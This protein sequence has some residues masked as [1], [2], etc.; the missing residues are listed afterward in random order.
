MKRSLTKIIAMLLMV[1]LILSGCVIKNAGTKNVPQKG[2]VFMWE[3][4]DKSGKGKLYLLGS[5]HAA[6]E[7]LYPLKP[8]ITDAFEKSDALAV[9]CDV[10]TVLQRSDYGELMKKVMYNDGTTIKDHISADLYDKADALLKKNGISINLLAKYKPF[11]LASTIASFQLTEWGYNPNDGID[12]HLINLAREQGKE[13]AE[14]ESVDFQYG[15]LGGFSDDIQQLELKSTVEGIEASKEYMDEMFQYWIDG[16]IKSF[17][18]LTFKEDPSLTPE[19]QKIYKGYMKQ[20]FDDRNVNMAAKAEEYL[21]SGKTYF[22]VVG[23]GH[24]VGEAG[25]VNLLKSKGYKVVQK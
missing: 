16:D 25:I 7:S 15:L 1:C 21:K 18:D 9:E 3:V 14:I 22:F 11:M 12:I 17:E 13:I 8:V 2:T 20:M 5:I 10:T 23:S 24:M 6:K 19:E 4:N